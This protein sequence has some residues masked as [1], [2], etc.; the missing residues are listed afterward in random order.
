MITVPFEGQG[1]VQEPL[2]VVVV[3]LDAAEANSAGDGFWRPRPC[4]V[5]LRVDG[6]VGGA[7]LRQPALRERRRRRTQAVRLCHVSHG[8]KKLNTVLSLSH[9]LT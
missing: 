3:R 5:L 6:R 1:E 4:A 2:G 7:R 9:D 8:P